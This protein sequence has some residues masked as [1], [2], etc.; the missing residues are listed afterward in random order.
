MVK[1]IIH[2]A[3][4]HIRTFRLHDEY[5]EV[6]NTLLNDIK[7]LVK[8]YEREEVR[9]VIAGDLVHQKIV[10]SNEQLILG[11]WLLRSLEKIAPVI[12]IAGNHDLLENNKDRMDS[13][14]PMVQFLPDTDINYF[15]E[16]KCYLDNN[17]VWCVYSIFE[18]NS[19]PDIESARLAF[20]D[21]K[22]YIGLFHGPIIGLK[23]DL[24]YEIDHGYN[25]EIFD[26]CDIVMCG[27]IHKRGFLTLK[28]TL[29]INEDELENYKKTT[30]VY[31]VGSLI[32]QNFGENVSKHGFLMWDVETRTYTEHDVDNNYPYYQ[33]KI[34]SL[35][36]IETGS[37][38]LTNG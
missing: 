4:I 26:G 8:D 24:G 2:L 34:T 7:N 9:I 37:E 25:L 33:F 14:T 31:Q 28:Q 3:D 12:I 13:I 29:E 17:I 30:L 32:Q 11:T 19:R 6:F 10:I 38:T 20:G 35:E 5:K 27:D 22:T 21:D 23:T 18:E 16:S 36:D 15:T 1:S